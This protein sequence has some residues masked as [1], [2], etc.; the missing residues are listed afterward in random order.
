MDT[1]L[2]LIVGLV[3]GVVIGWLVGG[4]KKTAADGSVDLTAQLNQVQLA[5][6][7]AETRV[8]GLTERAIRAE[9]DLSDLRDLQIAE[10]AAESQVLQKLAP[11]AQQ[12]AD[13]KLKVEQIEDSR[14]TQHTTLETLLSN[15][16]D[17]TR[18]LMGQTSALTKAMTNN[19]DRGDWGEAQLLQLVQEAGLVDRVDYITQKSVDST[20]NKSIPDMVIR[21][22]GGTSVPVDSKVP[23][24]SYYKA[25][26][27]EDREV[28]A[29]ELE[30]QRLMLEHAAALK[31][32]VMTLSTKKY[33]EGYAKSPQFVVAFIP[34]ESLLAAALT[35]DPGL[36]ELAMK[37]KVL[38]ATPVNLFSILKSI[39]LLWQGTADQEALNKVIVLGKRVF[40]RL[41]LIAKYTNE[42]G[43]HIRRTGDAYNTLVGS[44]ETSLLPTARELN[45][46]EKSQF[47]VTVIPEVQ[48]V[49]PDP[50]AF[51]RISTDARDEHANE[52]LELEYGDLA[53]R[54]DDEETPKN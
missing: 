33:W 26:E 50:R 15:A 20:D 14:K 5:L 36:L 3:A 21:M 23:F 8:E 25:M 47:G 28:P 42:I 11:V 9:K 34:K 53:T 49:N 24:N 27:I 13:M 1:F 43:N 6:A 38:L 12:L 35:A 30:Y 51:A 54:P 2:F 41:S 16:N 39:A 32:H 31:K 19:Q 17:I 29:R 48:T 37:N 18:T 46:L 45:D 52:L 10:K 44:L 40:E 22:P 4:R 7:T